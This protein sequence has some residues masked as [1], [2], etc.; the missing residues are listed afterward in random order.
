MGVEIHSVKPL[1]NS[2]FQI[3]FKNEDTLEFNKILFAT[4]SGRKA[5]N[6]LLAL[7]HTISDPVPSLFTFKIVDPRLENLSGLTFEKTECSL[8]EFGYSQLG[9]LLVTHWGAS[10]PAIL[11]LSAKGARE[12]F[13]KE[14]ETT[15]RIDFVPGIKKDEGRK[16]KRA[17][18]LQI[19]FQHARFRNSKKI[20]GKNIRNS[21]YRSIQ[22]VVRLIL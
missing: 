18:S 7:G 15:L 16:G 1:P 9:S 21:F 10:G 19:H 2:K 8:T 14:Y 13:N 6:W 4:G 3:K 11:K 20:L 5:W 12:L 22:K 17:S